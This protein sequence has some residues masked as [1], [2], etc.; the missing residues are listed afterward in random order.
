MSQDDKERHIE[1]IRKLLA[2]SGSSNE[3]EAAI[4]R[5]RAEV[6]MEKYAI[7]QAMLGQAE[8]GSGDFETDTKDSAIW[9]HKL[10]TAIGFIFGC[11]TAYYT[12]RNQKLT[13]TFYGKKPSVEIA[14]YV[15]E[16]V[17]RSLK[18]SWKNHLQE[19]KLRGLNSS[20]KAR[21]DFH[22]HFSI[23][24]TR[25]ISEVFHGMS[26]QE[27]ARLDD[28]LSQSQE[29]VADFPKARTRAVRDKEY[30]RTASLAGYR[31]GQSQTINIG[32]GQHT[33]CQIGASHG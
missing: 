29:Q 21:A 14:L 12:S 17:T 28:E 16:V 13:Y 23:G 2:L 32:V 4:A 18:Q 9:K 7:S 15:C 1:R 19:L 27:K 33:S 10:F 6:L 25:K 22:Y 30:D 24:V 11:A 20:A 3:H 8:F 26:E 5:R 31:A